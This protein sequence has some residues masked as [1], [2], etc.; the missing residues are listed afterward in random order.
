MSKQKMTLSSNELVAKISFKCKY[1]TNFG[2]SLYVVGN[3]ESLGNWNVEKALELSTTEETYPVWEKKDAFYCPLGTEITYKYITKD[4]KKNASWE[5]LPN[6]GNRKIIVDTEGN[7]SIEDEE[8]PIANESINDLEEKNVLSKSQFNP[9]ISLNKEGKILNIKSRVKTPKKKKVIKLTSKSLKRNTN[10]KKLTAKKQKENTVKSKNSNNKHLIKTNEDFEVNKDEI[11]INNNNLLL[12]DNLIELKTNLDQNFKINDIF[13]YDIN[14]INKMNSGLFESF[15]FSSNQSINNKDRL[16]IVNEFLPFSFQKKEPINEDD[17]KFVIIPDNNNFIYSSVKKL[18]DQTDCKIFWVGMEKNPIELD[19]V[20][21]MEL[22]DFLLESN[23]ILVDVQ[24]E[25]FE[26]YYIYYN[27]ILMPTFIDNSI[28]SNNEFNRDYTKYYNAFQLVNRKFSECLI[29]FVRMNDLIMINGMNLC[30]IPNILYPKKINCRIGIYTHLCFPSSDVFKAFPNSNDILNSILLC[31]VIGFHVYN[32]ARNFETVLERLF[33]LVPQIKSKG[34]ITIDHSGKHSFVFIKFCGT[35][36]DKILKI[37][38]NDNSD[39]DEKYL[40]YLD[41]YKNLIKDKTS[42]IS[43]DNAIETTELFLKFSAFKIYLEKNNDVK[44]KFILVQL[45]TY[46]HSN[47]NNLPR[48][49]EEIEKIKIEFGDDSVYYEE[50][51]EDGK[52]ID[53]RERLALFSL[54]NVFLVMQRYNRICSMIIEY[55]LVQNKDKIFGII[56]NESNS[57]PPKICSAKSINSYN[58]DQILKC[59]DGILKMDN[60]LRAENLNKDL[61]YIKSN[62]TVDFLKSFFGDLKLITCNNKNFKSEPLGLGSDFRIMKLSANFSQLT[63][64]ILQNKYNSSKCRLFFLDYEETLQSFVEQDSTAS[65]IDDDEYLLNKHTPSEKLVNVLKNL[66]SNPKNYVYIITGKPKKFLLSWFNDIENLGLGG[67][68][69]YYYKEAQKPNSD[70]QTLFNINDWSWKDTAYNIFKE[71]EIKTEGSKTKLKDSSI[72][73]NFKN[74]DQYSGYIQASDLSIHLSNIF[75]NSSHIEVVTGKDYVE[76]KPKNLNKGYF[77][78]YIIKKYI[79]EGKKPDYIF[80]CGDDISDE[81]MF[82]YLNFVN[83][84]SNRKTENMK[85]ITATMDKKP[86]AAQYYIP[87]P[88]ELLNLLD[89]L[90]GNKYNY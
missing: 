68:Y 80:A 37:V 79:N 16:V 21:K 86:S 61:A 24:K 13:T 46:N 53:Y 78:S 17:S 64:N 82:K 19:S 40:N 32:Y 8:Y 49:R 9:S 48:I 54:G 2:S 45:L 65:N 77:I 58:I 52:S 67:E 7:L 42:I 33:W 22:E 11:D 90:T 25:L 38:D 36:N 56:V 63:I 10:T 66:C 3:V 41:K 57:T 75:A 30:F 1:H 6:N 12:T 20:E 27:N 51:D 15:L 47:N 34:Y 55:L 4:A 39:K 5:F 44:D 60:T 14:L 72:S 84:Q 73:W 88:E 18:I 83:K 81:E 28:N 76:I 50:F 35:D 62:S 43:I 71:F 85:I 23:I 69:G 70:F 29:N 87:L 31:D 74:C 89:S 59:I 26:D